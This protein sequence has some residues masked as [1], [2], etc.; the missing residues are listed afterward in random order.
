M[1]LLICQ[2]VFI[3]SL[4]N[5][6]MTEVSDTPQWNCTVG[7]TYSPDVIIMPE[8]LERV[9]PALSE[10]GASLIV[11]EAGEE[12]YDLFKRTDPEIVAQARADNPRAGERGEIIYHFLLNR[13]EETSSK[14]AAE[15][16]GN[17]LIET[18]GLIGIDFI[19]VTANVKPFVRGKLKRR[20][21]SY[22]AEVI[23]LKPRQTD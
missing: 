10:I 13:D 23:P 14:D 4:Y 3:K 1:L 9:V 15:Y 19:E 18:L 7:F 22:T 8:I 5:M 21:N 20:A 11:L 17:M 2:L 6:R 16:C 12:M